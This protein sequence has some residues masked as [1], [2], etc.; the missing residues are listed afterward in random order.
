MIGQYF[1][2]GKDKADKAPILNAFSRLSLESKKTEEEVK[3][4]V[5]QTQEGESRQ[6]P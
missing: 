6:Q 5:E 3:A 2:N 1:S 4:N